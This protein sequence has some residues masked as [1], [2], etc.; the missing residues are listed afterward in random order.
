MSQPSDPR[1]YSSQSKRPA[2]ISELAERAMDYLWDENKNLKHHLRVAEKCHRDGKKF[3]RTGDLE[4]AFVQFARAASLVLEKLTQHR[5][6]YTLLNTA[7][8][9]KLGL[10]GQ[11]LLDKL[12][13]LKL[14]LVDRYDKWIQAYPDGI[15]SERTP[16]ANLLHPMPDDDQVQAAAQYHEEEQRQEQR[17]LSAEEAARWRPGDNSGGHGQVRLPSWSREKDWR[18]QEQ[19][20]LSRPRQR[21][22][23]EPAV[24][25]S[26]PSRSHLSVPLPALSSPFPAIRK[27]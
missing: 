22:F 2:S 25:L 16:D 17:R 5:D 24:S 7:Q 6:Y 15:N 11:D 1:P 14:T 3:M 18:R 8:R 12:S 4:N 10:N 21:S 13:D 19:E 26:H 23:D 20:T 9:Q 27:R